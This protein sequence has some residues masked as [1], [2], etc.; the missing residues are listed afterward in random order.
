MWPAAP[1]MQESL[2]KFDDVV[3]AAKAEGVA[4]RGYVSCVVGCPIQVRGAGAA[5][6]CCSPV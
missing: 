4:V 3:A 2:R 6:T 5:K 1:S